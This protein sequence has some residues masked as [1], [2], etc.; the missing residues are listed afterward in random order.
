MSEKEQFELLDTSIV[1]FAGEWAQC[2]FLDQNRQTKVLCWWD[3]NAGLGV[4][5]KL[6]CL[7][8]A[9]YTVISISSVTNKQTNISAQSFLDD[10]KDNIL[11][12]IQQC[13]DPSFFQ[14][15]H[16]LYFNSHVFCLI[17][18]LR[19]ASFWKDTFFSLF[20][21]IILNDDVLMFAKNIGTL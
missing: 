7:E 4:R 17:C 18:H 16:T 19:S 15:T 20:E 14:Y 8:L 21:V 9:V 5:N 12:I 6:P 2:R 3:D 1:G 10:P 11:F 13:I